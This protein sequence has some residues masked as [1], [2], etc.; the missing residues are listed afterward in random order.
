M[1]WV[2]LN[3]LSRSIT[4]HRPRL[5]AAI[6]QVLTSGWLV[7][8]PQHDALAAELAAYLGGDELGDVHVVPVGNGTDSLELALRAVTGADRSIVVTAAN[9]G[10]YASTAARRAGLTVRLADVEPRTHCLGVAEVAAAVGEHP[11]RVGAVVVTHL[12]GRA[13]PVGDLVRWCRPRGI[14]VVEDCAQALGAR[15]SQGPVGT[16]GDVGTLSFYPTKN[17][18]ALGDGGAVVTRSP[19]LAERVRLLRQYGWSAKYTISVPGAANSRLDELQAA[20]LRVRLELLD[21]WNARRREILRRYAAV[22]ATG[23]RVLPAEGPD[24]V[25]HLGVLECD[26][27]DRVIERLT[28]AGIRTDIHYPVPDHRQPAWAA[29]HVEARLPVTEALAGRV[30]SLPL[31][32]ELRD[33]EI[34]RVCDALAGL[35]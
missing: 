8:G 27:R 20:V 33:D 3:D 21:G 1:D 35:D 5:D 2:P 32:P 7:L 17:L 24:H 4:E 25:A 12:Y 14:P 34:E 10:G 15:T 11:D 16:I 31:F 26:E 30:L 23:A 18:G 22:P 19:E 9:A 13:A 28:A 29:E 6:A